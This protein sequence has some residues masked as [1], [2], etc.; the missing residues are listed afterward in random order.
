LN[1]TPLGQLPVIPLETVQRAAQLAAGGATRDPF[2]NAN[3]IA[4]A[5]DFDN[6][7]SVQSGIG[8]ESEVMRNLVAGV[9]FSYL[10]TVHLLRNRDYNV[11]IPV[12]RATD[13]ARRP[14][15]GL[16]SGTPRPIPTLAS[17]WVRESSS[18]SMYRAV[19]FSTQY[20]SRKV[21]AGSFYTWSE[22]FSDDD[23][24][25]D[26]T[27]VAYADAFDLV[28][29]YGYSRSDMR[30]Q[31]AGYGV[32]S[33]PLGFEVGLTLKARSGIPVNPLT[34]ADTNE[35]FGNT[36]RGYTAP[37]VS[38]ARNSF[39]NRKVISNDMRILKNFRIGGSETR[40]LQFST[41]F[42]NLL[43]L[44]NVVFSGVNGGVLGGTYGLGV[45]ANGQSVPVDIRFLRLR[46][47]DG[48]YDRQNAQA[49]TP[50]QVQFGLRFFF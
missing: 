6:P 2:T 43:N 40:R 28:G 45:G 34:G 12:V 16:R 49:G 14:F 30:H 26:A 46:N 38:L 13:A 15:Y 10:N 22:S 20:R 11:P 3:L 7:R 8:F 37:G 27:G 32:F 35:D 23:S 17:I 21:Q 41:E 47:T 25:R 31:F 42:F 4:M 39:R 44:D 19:T 29:E 33:L 36:D 48:T 1:R 18:R 9:Q 24:E 5:N 50:L